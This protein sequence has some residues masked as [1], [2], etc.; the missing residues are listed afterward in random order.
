MR[1]EPHGRALAPPA[2]VDCHDSQALRAAEVVA[3]PDV[4]CR[5]GQDDAR[6]GQLSVDGRK[7]GSREGW[8]SQTQAVSVPSTSRDSSEAPEE[9]ELDWEDYNY[10]REPAVDGGR[11]A[12]NP[13]AAL[14]AGIPDINAK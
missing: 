5:V 7:R 8:P 6:V 10:E 2:K 9:R 11:Q 1:R 3:H 12:E 13:L 14:L 4:R